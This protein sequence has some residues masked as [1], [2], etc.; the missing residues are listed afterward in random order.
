AALA[1]CQHRTEDSMDITTTAATI[2]AAPAA[3]AGTSWLHLLIAALFGW[4]LPQGIPKDPNIGAQLKSGVAVAAKL[5][6]DAA[7]VATLAGQPALAGG[8]EA[9]GKI[10]QAMTTTSDPA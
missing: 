5:A 8:L 10:A 1:G 6:P 7:V 3:V 4:G 2:A 9:A